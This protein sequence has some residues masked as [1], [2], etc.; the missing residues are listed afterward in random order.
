MEENQKLRPTRIRD[1]VMKRYCC[2][3]CGKVFEENSVPSS[4]PNCGCPSSAFK[5]QTE[6][7]MDGNISPS[8]ESTNNF[9]A[10]HTVNGLA[11]LNL[12]IGIIVGI[13]GLI[14]A[15][16]FWGKATGDV[17]FT[18]IYMLVGVLCFIFSMLFFLLSLSAWAFLKLLV[19]ISYRLTRL[20]NKYNPK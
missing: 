20:D 8:L 15:I 7:L 12:T 5:E 9:A 16:V 19:N 11:G 4:C 17:G 1:N 3:D 13:V 10:E 18:Q 6:T 2:P 14:A